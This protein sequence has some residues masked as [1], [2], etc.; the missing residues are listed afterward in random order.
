MI[1]HFSKT[2]HKPLAQNIIDFLDVKLTQPEAILG[3]LSSISISS[4]L[5]FPEFLIY[6]SGFREGA[7]IS[8]IN[9]IEG[10]FKKANS[11]RT[12]TSF[13]ESP[14]HLLARLKNKKIF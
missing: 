9:M 2:R 11:K 14:R 6:K 4:V 8:S 5:N 12:L 3:S 1:G 13:S 10:P 7:S